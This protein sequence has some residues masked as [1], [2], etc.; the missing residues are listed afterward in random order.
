ME[1]VE[2]DP[3]DKDYRPSGSKHRKKHYRSTMSDGVLRAM[4]D[5]LALSMFIK[6]NTLESLA[7]AEARAQ[8][9]TGTL[10]GIPQQCDYMCRGSKML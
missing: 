9:C 8:L 3:Q 5:V 4:D 7:V 2:S 6:G 1:D 10:Q